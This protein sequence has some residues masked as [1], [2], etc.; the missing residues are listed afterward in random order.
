MLYEVITHF[1]SFAPSI[2][3][4]KSYVTFFE[5]IAKMKILLDYYQKELLAQGVDMSKSLQMMT[6]NRFEMRNNF[7]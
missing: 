1:N 2:K 3:R 7:V 4:A 6:Y 5:S